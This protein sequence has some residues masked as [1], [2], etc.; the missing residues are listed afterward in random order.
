MFFLPV[1]RT[2]KVA[3]GILLRACPFPRVLICG[4]I[5]ICM[6]LI[7][8]LFCVAVP[9]HLFYGGE[10]VIYLICY[11]MWMGLFCRGFF[12]NSTFNSTSEDL[13][14]FKSTKGSCGAWLVHSIKMSLVFS[15]YD[16][17]RIGSSFLCA[18]YLFTTSTLPRGD[19]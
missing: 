14:F 17:S 18:L 8:F 5:S 19:W 1:V 9:L 11:F 16:F 6:C 10:C 2:I 12:S 13:F 3:F 15:A 4:S 7:P